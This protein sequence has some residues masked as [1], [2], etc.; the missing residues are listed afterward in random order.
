LPRG[1]FKTQKRGGTGVI[2]GAIKEG[3]AVDKVLASMTH[4]TLFF[5]TNSGK[6]FSIKTYEIPTSTRTAKGQAIV[7]FLQIAPEEK[8]TSILKIPKD[9]NA[10]Y[11]IMQTVKGTIKKTPLK[12]FENVRR[13]GLVAIRLQKEDSLEW[14]ET[15]S[16]RDDIIIAT[17]QG[18]SIRFKESQVRAMGRTAAGVRA[19]RLKNDDFVISMSVVRSSV[20][21]PEYLVVSEKGYGKRTSLDKY[22]TQSR[23]GSGI[24]TAKITT[25]TGSL[26]SA[27]VI[28]DEVEGDLIASSNRGQIIRTTLKDISILGR[29]TQGV[30]IMRLKGGEKVAATTVI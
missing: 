6:V 3:D 5:F 7:N 15:T 16:S 4:D 12:D 1:T 25:K 19:I 11:L 9:S 2:G 24:K 21:N 8:I 17:S 23:G 26:I 18:Q 10:K 28:S 30:R 20:K 13:S 27:H 29:A 14:V 22:K